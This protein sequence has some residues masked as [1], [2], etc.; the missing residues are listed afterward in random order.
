VVPWSKETG[1]DLSFTGKM[2]MVKNSKKT[3]LGRGRRL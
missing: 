3:Y 1:R 2:E